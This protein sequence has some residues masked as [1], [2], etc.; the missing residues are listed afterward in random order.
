MLCFAILA[1]FTLPVF[2]QQLLPDIQEA[3]P[4]HLN[5]QNEQK[6]EMLR[7]TTG[8]VNLGEGHL[9]ILGGG[10]VAPCVVDGVPYDQCT[11]ATQQILDA[12]GNVVATHLAGVAF[13][14]PAHNHW[15]QSDVAQFEIRRGALNGPLLVAGKKVTFC[16]VDLERIE[17]VRT[18][19]SRTYFDC[20]GALQGISPGWADVYHHSLEG[21]E[22][23][24]TGAPE[25]IYYL[26]HLANPAGN[27][28]ESDYTNNFAWVKFQLSRQG[29]NPEIQ[30]L[31]YSLCAE[32]ITCPSLGNR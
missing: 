16:L 14:H 6:R 10:Q 13:F 29:S 25:G 22:L 27:W 3:I 12:V 24:I 2:C 15:H 31:Q 32:G 21:Q 5:I 9:Q 23:D 18:T 26:T 30:I 11:H 20:N 7:F 4:D 28:L 1:V 19:K 17:G 8:H